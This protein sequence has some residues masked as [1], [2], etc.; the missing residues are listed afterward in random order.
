[1]CH[2][3]QLSLCVCALQDSFATFTVET[4]KRK[5][6]SQRGFGRYS[7][8]D[9][10]RIKHAGCWNVLT[11]SFSLLFQEIVLKAKFLQFN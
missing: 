3:N 4:M 2:R 11:A 5:L 6:N 7:K 10:Q 8:P 9:L 1:M